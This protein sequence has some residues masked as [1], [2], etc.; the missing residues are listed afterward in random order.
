[1]LLPGTDGVRVR[2]PALLLVFHLLPGL[3]ESLDFH[4]PSMTHVG[5]ISTTPCNVCATSTPK[6]PLAAAPAPTPASAPA[7]APPQAGPGANFAPAPMATP[8]SGSKAYDA[9]KIFK[10]T[11]PPPK[12]GVNIPLVAGL[13]G[14]GAVVVGGAVAAIVAATQAAKHKKEELPSTS[15][16]ISFLG[17]TPA[18]LLAKGSKPLPTTT[19]APVRTALSLP[20]RI[21][22]SEIEVLDQT[23]FAI[24]D[25]IK[26]GD[27]INEVKG[28]SSIILDH[29]VGHNHAA[30]VT[31]ERVSRIQQASPTESIDEVLGGG[32]APPTIRARKQDDGGSGSSGVAMV[33]IGLLVCAAAICMVS[34]TMFCCSRTKGSRSRNMD[35]EDYDQ[36]DD[37]DEVSELSEEESIPGSPASARDIVLAPEPMQVDPLA[38]THY[39]VV[40]PQMQP[41]AGSAIS[42]L[43]VSFGVAP[44]Y[45]A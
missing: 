38:A 3:T 21:G 22:D 37:D 36:V 5:A 8:S 1:M 11:P 23:G 15:P 26:I 35:D 7:P 24:G 9:D 33:I 44:T 32:M 25:V 10:Q 2:W 18:P 19:L 17:T 27:E 16:S 12:R 13:A 29:P 14:G 31:V 45:V 28:F 40:G 41:S 34:L 6:V 4:M 30:G 43:G 20:I 39:A 42:P